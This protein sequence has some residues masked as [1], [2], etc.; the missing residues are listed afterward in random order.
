MPSW[1]ASRSPSRCPTS[2]PCTG[3]T[4]APARRPDLGSAGAA[5]PPVARHARPV[6][7]PRQR[8]DA[9]ADPG[10]AGDPALPRLPRAVPDRRGV[11]D[12]LGRRRG[13]RV[14]GPGVQPARR[15]APC[16]SLH[17]HAGVRRPVP[18][19]G[20]RAPT[21]ARRRSLHR[22]G[23]AGL[24]LRGR[25]RRGRHQRG[26]GAGPGGGPP[27]HPSRGPGRGRCR[28]AGRRGVGVEPGD[29]RPR[30]GAL[31]AGGAPLHGVSRSRPGAPGAPVAAASPI[32]RWGRPV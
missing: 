15:E 10:P 20:E 14:G 16:S 3:V 22:Q 31:P 26:P 19:D 27:A 9:P 32:R 13:G 2:A 5:R 4:G 21:A 12:G 1:P 29:A 11:R 6:G 24:R 25:C 7:D 23:A 8:G 17:G 28:A 30:R 18:A